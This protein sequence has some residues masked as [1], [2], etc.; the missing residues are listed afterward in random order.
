[1]T[2][3]RQVS[4][5]PTV[6]RVGG[7]GTDYVQGRGAGV[8]HQGTGEV[9][10]AISKVVQDRVVVNAEGTVAV[11]L[12]SAI[13]MCNDDLSAPLELRFS[14]AGLVNLDTGSYSDPFV[15]VYIETKG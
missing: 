13:V 1:M 6:E 9:D 7:T 5:N 15:V 10:Q 11:D 12:P 2:N 3:C 14:C 8:G 4:L